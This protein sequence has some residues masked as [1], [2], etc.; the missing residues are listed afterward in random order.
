MRI[1]VRTFAAM[2]SVLFSNDFIDISLDARNAWLYL[3]WKG[4][5]TDES[6]KTA[7]NKAIELL[8]EHGVSKILN[9]NAKVLGI[10]T[11]VAKWLAFDAL[12]RARQAGMSRFAHVYGPSRLARVSAE[13]ALILL[14]SRL[15]DI[16]TF[17]DIEQAKAWLNMRSN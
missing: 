10:W 14:S 5:Q 12:P 6:I 13:A 11:G 15:K 2:L 8:A 1:E 9:D 16:K 7:C 3:D 4:Y 17:D